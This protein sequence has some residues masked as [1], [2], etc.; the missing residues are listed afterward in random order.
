M[1]VII[2]IIARSV[3]HLPSHTANSSTA[4]Q[5]TLVC[6]R[7]LKIIV[8]L[9]MQF[10][11]SMDVSFVEK[12]NVGFHSSSVAVLITSLCQLEIKDVKTVVYQ[13]R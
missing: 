6:F 5:V 13:N 10:T 8:M 7:T 1:N 3:V 9:M 4:L 11:N 12:G 2:F